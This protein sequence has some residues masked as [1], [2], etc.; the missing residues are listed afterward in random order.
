MGRAIVTWRSSRAALSALSTGEAE[1]TAAA[2]GFQT[3]EGVR[4]LLDT[5]RV[6]IP[7]VQVWVDNVAGN[8]RDHRG[9]EAAVPVLRC[10][11]KQAERGEREG[12]RPD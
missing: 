1:L 9:R 4:H 8:Y 10:P 3:S 12:Q 5:L 6:E 2:T 11:R 7:R